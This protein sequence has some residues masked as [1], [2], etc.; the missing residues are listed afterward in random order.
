MGRYCFIEKCSTTK[1]KRQHEK[2]DT[3]LRFFGFPSNPALKEKWIEA[4]AT[5]NR[6]K[7]VRNL[8]KYSR[9][10]VLHFTSDC[11]ESIG[12]SQVR[13]KPNAVPTIFPRAQNQSMMQLLPASS[14]FSNA[15]VTDDCI[16]QSTKHPESENF[17]TTETDSNNESSNIY[18]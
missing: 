8:P 11:L 14:K 1:Y 17:I 3:R 7:S 5:Q 10:C 18:N 16:P 4:I 15:D 2:N 13:L 6:Q 9:I 12:Y